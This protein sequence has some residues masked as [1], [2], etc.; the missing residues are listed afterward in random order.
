M[1]AKAI[2][3]VFI[4]SMLCS[5]G[6]DAQSFMRGVAAGAKGLS[7]SMQK[8]ADLDRDI[9]FMRKKAEI[10]I[11]MNRRIQADRIAAERQSR[12]VLSEEEKM[13]AANP[14]WSKIFRSSAFNS[15]LVTRAQ[16]Y[17]DSCKKTNSAEVATSC[18]DD[19][20][21]AVILQAR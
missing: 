21:S 8:Q 6:A 2:A 14:Q 18:I 13:A 4:L 12:P 19:F 16:A 3:I 7:E 9:E 15:W 11:E 5:H 20:F 10:E 17:Q 1:K